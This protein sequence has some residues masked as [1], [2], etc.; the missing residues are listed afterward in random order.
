MEIFIP[1][2]VPSSKNSRMK[3]KSGAIIKN[4]RCFLYEKGVKKILI[5]NRDLFKDSIRD[6]NKPIFIGLHFIRN[7]RR[8]ADF[9][10]L[11]QL[12]ADLLVKYNWIED[13]NMN[14][15]FFIPFRIDGKWHSINVKEGGVIIHV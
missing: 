12:I 11:V 1:G 9:H 2:N 4:P 10:N 5:D 13:D 6:K 3:T 15:V 8:R 7:S 14:E